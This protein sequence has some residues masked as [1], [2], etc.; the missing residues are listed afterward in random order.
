MGEIRDAESAALALE[1]AMTGHLVLSSLHTHTALETLV[2]L[3]DL[4]VRPYLL[5]NALKGVISQQLL[6]RLS[7]GCTEPVPSDAAVITRL[8]T[9]G[10]L[11]ADWSGVLSRGKDCEGFPPGGESGRVGAY[12]VMFITDQLRDRIDR[13]APRSELEKALDPQYFFS[14]SRYCR[15]LLKA[16]LVAPEHVER[17]IPKKPM[18]FPE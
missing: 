2:R 18:S 14:F 3:Q 11:E 7:P 10:V 15:F 17:M 12:E 16:G 1:A 13:S 5:A 8:K 6:P 4:E 9:L